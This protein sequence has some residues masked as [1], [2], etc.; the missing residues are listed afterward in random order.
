MNNDNNYNDDINK[1]Q[2]KKAKKFSNNNSISHI[3]GYSKSVTKI[4][5]YFSKLPKQF[6]IR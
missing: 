2:K 5:G 3:V 4:S 1:E 6:L